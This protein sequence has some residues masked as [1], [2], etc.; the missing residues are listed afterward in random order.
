MHTSLRRLIFFLSLSLTWYMLPTLLRTTTRLARPL[1]AHPRTTAATG[2]TVLAS[3]SLMGL[4]SSS[5]PTKAGNGAGEPAAEP[6]VRKSEQEW[7]AQLNPEQFRV[8]RQ[9]GTE[10]PG[11][12]KY[13]KFKEEG[14][15]REW[16]RLHSLRLRLTSSLDMARLCRMRG[17]LVYVGHQVVSRALGSPPAILLTRVALFLSDSG[18]GWP[19]FF[20]AIPGAVGRHEDNSMFMKRIE[21]VCNNCGPR[22]H[23]E[24][25][26][27][28]MRMTVQAVVTLVMC[29]KAKASASRRTKDTASTLCRECKETRW[30][31]LSRELTKA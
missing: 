6:K 31:S 14:L 20:D 16:S 30:R 11:T 7:R 15:Y 9:K 13:D 26:S 28:L 23:P 5:A 21:I 2:T 1:L 25:G 10:R 17:A 29:F 27:L 24:C 22:L 3:S 8:I 12:G 19:A 18:C 4:F